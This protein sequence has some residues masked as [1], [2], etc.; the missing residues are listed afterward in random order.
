MSHVQSPRPQELLG[1]LDALESE[2]AMEKETAQPD[3]VPSY[4]LVRGQSLEPQWYHSKTPKSEVS[5][6]CVRRSL[7]RVR[8]RMRCGT[9]QEPDL[10]AAPSGVPSTPEAPLQT[11]PA[12]LP[13]RTA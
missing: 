4:L 10:P 11:D 12:A 7:S 6:C 8:A 3:A 1:E 9:T 2:L 13:A 5:G